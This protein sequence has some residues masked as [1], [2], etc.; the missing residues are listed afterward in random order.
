LVVIYGTGSSGRAAAA[1]LK[2]EEIIFYDDNDKSNSVSIEEAKQKAL[3]AGI[4]ILSPGIG[5]DNELCRFCD[6]NGV[7]IV[8]EFELAVKHTKA[9]IVAI[10]GTNGKTTVCRL[11]GAGLKEAGMS[12]QLAGNIGVPFSAV[13]ENMTEN[14]IAVLEV[15]SFQLEKFYDFSPH[16]SAITNVTPDHLDRHKSMEQYIRAKHNIYA[17]QTKEQ[18]TVLNYSDDLIRRYYTDGTAKKLLFDWDR[19]F[20]CTYLDGKLILKGK[21]I[22]LKNLSFATKGNIENMMAAALVL[23]CLGVNTEQIENAFASFKRDRHRAEYVGSAAG[24]DFINDSKATN[25]YAALD[26][27]NSYNNVFLIMGGSDKGYGFEEF[28]IKSKPKYVCAVGDTAE[29]IIS[30][31]KNTGYLTIEKAETLEQAVQKCYQKALVEG[32][33]VL[34][35]PAC[36]SFDRYKNYAQRGDEFVRIVKE[37]TDK[38]KL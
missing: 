18:F 9:K 10:T 30:D 3:Q 25:I 35:A 24:V 22:S 2:N 21:P 11:I 12:H 31:A 37:I 34:L 27:A 20:D 13:C 17:A 32:G 5:Y 36:A 4:L 1:L 14:E 6:R 29:R 38:K 7:K 8:G 15:S 33:T 16:V 23:D 19:R 26:S 28:F